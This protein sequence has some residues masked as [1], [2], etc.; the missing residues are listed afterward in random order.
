M[1]DSFNKFSREVMDYITNQ[2]CIKETQRAYRRCFNSLGEYLTEK[3]VSYSEEE[4]NAWLLSIHT[5]RATIG[6]YAAAVHKLNDLYLCGE[7]KRYHY[8]PAK[9]TAGKLCVEFKDIL[10]KIKI[11]ISA[12]ANDTVSRH[13]QQCASILFRIQEQGITSISGIIYKALIDEFNSSKRKP[14][15]SRCSHHTSL[16]LLLQ[17]L[18]DKNLVP[19]GYTLF[20]DAMTMGKGY[21]WNNVPGEKIAGLKKLQS[22]NAMPLDSFLEMRDRLYQTHFNEGYSRTS[23]SGIL[24]I[25][26]LFYLFMDMNGLSYCPSIARIWLDS[27]KPFL[28]GIEY[29]RYRRVLYIWRIRPRKP[30]SGS[31]PTSCSGKRITSVFRTGASPRWKAS[32][33]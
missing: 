33:A 1:D 22:S 16:R 7:I 5:D 11:H 31:T 30:S 4:V 10:E 32:L 14:Y 28:D 26:N 20:V 8:N 27:V 17:F 13:S 15:Y 21:F 6:L 2:G 3:N 18:F 23:L 29:M 19:F 24:R 9:T 12:G 25:T